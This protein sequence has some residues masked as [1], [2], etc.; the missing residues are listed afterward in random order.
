M[1]SGDEMK[2]KLIV[3][4]KHRYQE[5]RD[6]LFDGFADVMKTNNGIKICYTEE[7]KEAC[8]DVEVKAD[9]HQ[10]ELKRQAET[11]SHMLFVLNEK[12]QGVLSTPYGDISIELLTHRYIFKEQI[13]TLEYDIYND[14]SCIGGYRIIWSIKEA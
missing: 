4:R 13:I 10:L 7:N 2:K 3:K 12:T 8:V 11:K 1:V 14:D 6:I 9:K 5:V